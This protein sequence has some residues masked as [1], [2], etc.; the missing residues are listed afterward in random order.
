MYKMV[1]RSFVAN[2]RIPE[3]Y[4]AGLVNLSEMPEDSYVSFLEAAKRIPEPFIN[5]QELEV[6]MQSEVPALSNL[7]VAQTLEL[8]TSLHR[9]RT[10]A[11]VSPEKLANDVVEA[12][13][14]KKH[15]FGFSA[16]GPF[17]ERLTKLLSLNTFDVI[18]VKAKELQTQC[19]RTYCDSR[20]LTDIRPVFGETITDPTAMVLIHTLKIGFHDAS[21]SSHK[22][23][24][25]ALDEADILDLKQA[26]E[27]AEQK[28]KSLKAVLNKAQ[29]K[30]VDLS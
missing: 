21:S 3:Q 16:D 27:R 19:E 30:S 13:Q 2:L 4:R 26:L 1:E 11:G 12:I 25:I 8:L 20:V 15:E 18:A 6:W 17:Q 7:E 22:D 23:I 28:S 5:S 10:K 14:H 29:L 24:Y 9:V